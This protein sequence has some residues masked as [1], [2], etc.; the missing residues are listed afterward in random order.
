MKK[1]PKNIYD[2]NSI[3]EMGYNVTSFDYNKNLWRGSTLVKAPKESFDILKAANVDTIIDLYNYFPLQKKCDENKLNYHSLQAPDESF[4]SLPVFQNQELYIYEQ[5]R[6]SCNS[7]STKED[8]IDHYEHSSRYFIDQMVP[9]VQSL[10]KG[11]C[12]ICCQFGTGLT[13]KCLELFTLFDPQ[14]YTQ[15]D[16]ITESKKIAFVNLY[17]NLTEE[18]KSKMGWTK[19][20]DENFVSH[21]ESI[22]DTDPYSNNYMSNYFFF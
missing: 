12:Y 11:N 20:F 17:N 19:E 13:S 5:M 10:Q 6:F 14:R 2:E 22:T 15:I 18:D 16:N 21:L 4:F 7:K 3:W 1:P 9:I 8:F